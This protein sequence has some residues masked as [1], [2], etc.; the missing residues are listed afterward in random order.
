MRALDVGDKSQRVARFHANT[1]EALAEMTGA[2]GLSHPS[3]FMPWHM[4]LRQGDKSMVQGH[5]VFGY[6]P[7]GYLLDDEAEDFKGNKGRWGRARADSFAPHSDA[8]EDSIVKS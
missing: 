1:M 3:E 7:E 5:E 8:Y 4:M 6:L 2:A